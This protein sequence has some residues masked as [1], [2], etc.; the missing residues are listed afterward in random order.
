MS[1]IVIVATYA[2]RVH[3]EIAKSA[4]DAEHIQSYLEA[5]DA[6]GM[7]PF[8]FSGHGNGVR[9]FIKNRNLTQAKKILHL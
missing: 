9:L 5:D 4:L 3:A 1:D 6:G 7:Y 2:N 8:A